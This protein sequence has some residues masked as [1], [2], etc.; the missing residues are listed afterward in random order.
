MA[1]SDEA[2]AAES[3]RPDASPPSS[4]SV[5]DE[6]DERE[7]AAHAVVAQDPGSPGPTAEEE[8]QETHAPDAFDAPDAAD[9]SDAVPSSPGLTVPEVGAAAA[10][11]AE[12]IE[13]MRSQRLTSLKPGPDGETHAVP[14]AQPGDEPLPG[15]EVIGVAIPPPTETEDVS[16]LARSGSLRVV[17]SS[18]TRTNAPAAARV[19]NDGTTPAASRGLFRKLKW[20]GNTGS[21]SE[22]GG[23]GGEETPAEESRPAR[24][25]SNPRTS[26]AAQAREDQERRQQLKAEAD[27]E[28]HRRECAN[29]LNMCKIALK[30]MIESTIGLAPPIHDSHRPLAQLLLVLEAVLRHGVRKRAL[31]A[32][33]DVFALFDAAD[34]GGLLAELAEPAAAL[35]PD[36]VTLVSIVKQARSHPALRTNQ[37][38][39]RF[40]LRQA[41]QHKLI[42][43]LVRTA[44]D[45]PAV[46]HDAFEPW[47]FLRSEDAVVLAGLLMGLA[48]LE[49]DLECPAEQLDTDTDV[50]DLSLYFKDGNYLKPATAENP[51]EEDARFS[52][53]TFTA[54]SDQNARLR[55]HNRKLEQQLFSSNHEMAETK[56]QLVAA[57]AA[58]DEARAKV[59]ELQQELA[60]RKELQ[61]V[62]ADISTERATYNVSREG[63]SQVLDAT[64]QQ[65][66]KEQQLREEMERELVSWK[67]KRDE[68]SDQVQGLEA[69]LAQRQ[70]ANDNLRKQ[71]KD[72]K[73]L[74]LQ[75][76]STVQELQDKAKEADEKTHAIQ[77]KCDQYQGEIQGLTS[78]LGDGETARERLEKTLVQVTQ[79]LK[80]RSGSY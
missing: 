54:L 9:A 1:D 26:A 59:T 42:S 22:E 8:Q 28:G 55:E 77:R 33:R 23:S 57:Q 52:E 78:K 34:R 64:T 15:Q 35:G 47:A 60:E 21:T 80:V 5:P 45:H 24:S 12:L 38:R 32:N 67:Q 56:E 65:M 36:Q 76:L 30:T 48:T 62:E 73:G 19:T 17:P 58:A 66:A 69:K 51:D 68:L 53:E 16:R 72:V 25:G 50:L 43:E 20:R 37:G 74:N 40:C 7:D 61:A 44:A 18:P 6:S 70:E 27:A 4:G 63:L 31:A 49:L 46:L 75:M 2:A 39:G 13:K 29:M 71:L 14:V 41:T 10:R 11:R 79:R 3:A